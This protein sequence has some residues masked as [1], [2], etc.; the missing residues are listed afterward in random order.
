MGG[1]AE[2]LPRHARNDGFLAKGV[3]SWLWGTVGGLARADR[4]PPPQ[5]PNVAGGSAGGRGDQPSG[6]TRGRSLAL[7]VFYEPSHLIEDGGMTPIAK[8]C[9]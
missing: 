3:G 9:P 8:P 1:Q 5:F 4:K 7:V 2:I 6:T